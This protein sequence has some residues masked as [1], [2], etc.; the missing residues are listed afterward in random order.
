MGAC[1]DKKVFFHEYGDQVI[2]QHFLVSPDL[3]PDLFY[4]SLY[5]EEQAIAN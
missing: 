1:T 2:I 3:E 4:V 5:P